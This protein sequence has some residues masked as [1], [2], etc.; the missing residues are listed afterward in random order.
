MSLES[1]QNFQHR[2]PEPD[3]SPS[4][5]SG[6]AITS[7]ILGMLSLFGACLTGI[8]GLILG[9]IGLGEIHKSNGRV[10]GRG[11]AVCGIVF[12]SLGIMWTAM[13]LLLLLPA[14]LLPAVKAV[15]DKAREQVELT[16]LENN[17]EL[18]NLGRDT[19]ALSKARKEFSTQIIRNDYSPEPVEK[20]S[21]SEF[22]LIHYQ[23][24]ANSLAA[25][26]TPAPQDGAKHPAIIWITGGHHNSIGDVWTPRERSNDQSASAF[27]KAGIVMMFA[28]TR[29]GN[30]NPG[31]REGFLGEVDDILAAADH[32]AK[33][34][35][36]DPEQIYLGGH[37][38]G[39]TLAMLVGESSD[40]FR[41]IF[42]LGPVAYAHTYR[43]EF[44]YCDPRDT[45][46]MELRS[47]IYWLPCVSNP[48]Y[49]FEGEENGNW[50]QLKKMA[51]VNL[52]PNIQFHKVRYH[53]HFSLISP[54]TEALAEQIS[55]GKI[56]VDSITKVFL[57]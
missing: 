7:L 56:N 33:L 41:A 17:T 32:L 46:E 43:G 26:V 53:D 35:Y 36:V 34:P 12:N 51:D 3:G 6:K 15:R 19:D 55:N 54:L 4:T 45:K 28:S 30:D 24:G 13:L 49:V 38:T 29:G 22:E 48:M 40:K 5:T 52:N 25:Y 47:P 11:I 37:S 18:I 39:G 14:L 44:V 1:K 16:N 23:S 27:R 8:P 21:N 20:P 42:A 50:D 2:Q 31:K 9:I 57:D 10:G